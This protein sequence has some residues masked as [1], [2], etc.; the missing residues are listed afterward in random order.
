LTQITSQ[1]LNKINL[2][3]ILRNWLIGYFIFE[4]EQHGEDCAIY[5]RMVLKNL[6]RK[7]VHIKGMSITN[8]I[9]S[10]SSIWCILKLV[11]RCLTNLRN[12]GY[13]YLVKQGLTT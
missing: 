13:S 7:L 8:L 6:A 11:R 10:E 9:C 5:G 12:L 1:A 2:Y 3:N 4:F